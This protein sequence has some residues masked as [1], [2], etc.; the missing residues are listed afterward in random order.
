MAKD[1]LKTMN[2]GRKHE[3]IIVVAPG[4]ALSQDAAACVAAMARDLYPALTLTFHPQCFLQHGHFAGDDA[5]RSAAFLEA[6]N[7]PGHDAVWFALGGY[8]SCRL[9][10]E[11][12]N[13][14]NDHA[15]AKTYLGYSDTGAILAR[16]QRLGFEG[17][18]HGPMPGDI[19]R[20]GGE[21]AVRRSLDFLAGGARD[22]IEAHAAAGGRHAAFNI[23]VLSHVIGTPWAPALDGFVLHLEEVAEYLYR[24]D[25]AL[26]TILSSETARACA[27]VR[28]GR[29]SDIP[30]NDIAFGGDEVDSVKYWCERNGVAYLGRSDIGHDTDNKIV[31]FGE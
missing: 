22:G 23:T 30:E 10:D 27:G 17:L 8:G 12:F 26:F 31:P 1:P 24:I 28:L 13:A 21:T 20:P 18:A 19:T 16:L 4:R 11:V 15:R 14:L 2:V 3:R 7:D 29:C 5:A 9:A 6:A 25:R